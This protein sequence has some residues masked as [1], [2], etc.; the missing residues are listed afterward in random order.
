VLLGDAAARP[1]AAAPPL[2]GGG[3]AGR[4]DPDGAQMR[5]GITTY[6]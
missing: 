2:G 6:L 3:R 4:C 1:A 5:I